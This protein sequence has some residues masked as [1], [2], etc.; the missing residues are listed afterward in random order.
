M[1]IR[2]VSKVNP[3]ATNS[4]EEPAPS[5]SSLHFAHMFR[6]ITISLKILQLGTKHRCTTM[7]RKLNNN[8]QYGKKP[9]SLQP[10]KAY[11]VWSKTLIIII[12]FLSR[13]YCAT[14]ICS[15]PAILFRSV[16]PKITVLITGLDLNLKTV[17]QHL[18]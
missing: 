4:G 5:V 17:S 7:T 12:I 1:S 14:W 6:Q 8:H 10:M 18:P 16:I 13:L 2:G 11:Q 15:K 3:M 9:S